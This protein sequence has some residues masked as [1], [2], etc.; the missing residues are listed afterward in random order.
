MKILVDTNIVLDWVLEREPFVT[1]AEAVIQAIKTKQV[2]GYLTATT[3]TDV[4]YIARKPKGAVSAKA[5]IA[6]LLT[7]MQICKVDRR[8]LQAAVASELSDLEDAV[9]L[10]CAVANNVDA[11]V[12]RNFAGFVDS[13]V[14]I[15]SPGELLGELS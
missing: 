2:K 5:Y 9:Q 15:K 6:E 3:V 13:P 10:A 1:D 7:F 8:I 11:I 4:F 12:T 14:P